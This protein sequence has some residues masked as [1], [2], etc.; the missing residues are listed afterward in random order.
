MK[1]APARP[2]RESDRKIG[3]AGSSNT[4]TAMLRLSVWS[5]FGRF[6]S[7]V[8]SSARR[9]AAATNQRFQAWVAGGRAR[10]IRPIH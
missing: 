5:T 2:C 10:N 6:N 7:T 8:A 1:Y 9:A 3:E 4:E